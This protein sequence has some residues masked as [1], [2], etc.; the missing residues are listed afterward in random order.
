MLVFFSS[1][2]CTK[3]ASLSDRT[4]SRQIKIKKKIKKEKDKKEKDKK[5]K[6]KE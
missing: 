2:T 1:R 4:R 5:E 6:D 3:I